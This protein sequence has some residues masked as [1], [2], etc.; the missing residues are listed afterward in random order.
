MDGCRI[1][2]VGTKSAIEDSDPELATEW[3]KTET[4]GNEG[5]AHR[6]AKDRWSLIK[7]VSR[8]GIN[9][10]NKRPSDGSWVTDHD[11]HVV[12]PLVSLLDRFL[13][14]LIGRLIFYP[15][16]YFLIS[17]N[18]DYPESSDFRT[19]EDAKDDPVWV[20]ILGPRSDRPA[21]AHGRMECW[22]ETSEIASERSQVD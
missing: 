10:K 8:I 16:Y 18:L 3:R 21:S 6:T 17:D 14:H 4:R 11:A 22:E 2:A 9:A 13:S 5:R 1:R 7:L 19:V 15:I 20:E 12:D